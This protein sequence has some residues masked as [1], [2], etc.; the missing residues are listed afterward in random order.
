MD[1]AVSKNDETAGY[2]ALVAEGMQ[3]MLFEVVVLKHPD[4]FSADAVAKSK[5]R[6]AEWRAEEGTAI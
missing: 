1:N 2:Q 3:D 6:L 4:V 5:K